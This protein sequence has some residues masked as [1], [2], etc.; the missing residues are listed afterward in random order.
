MK[1]LI[2]GQTSFVGQGVGNWFRKKAPVPQVDFLSVRDDLWRTRDFSGYDAVIFAAAL[3]HHPEVTDWELYHRIN[4]Q[5]PLDFAEHVKVQG[6]K[7]FVFF[8]TLSVYRA[9]RTLPEGT[10]IDENTPL[11]PLSLYGKSK[12]MAEHRLQ[13]LQTGDFHVSIVR[14]SYVYGRGCQGRHLDVKALLAR[15]LPLLPDAFGNVKMGMVHIDNLAQLCWLIVNS[16]CSGVY[17]AQDR[18]PMS[19]TDILRAL[20]PEKKSIRCGWLLRPFGR[21]SL[22]NRLFGGVAFSEELSQCPLGEYRVV[23]MADGIRRTM[24]ETR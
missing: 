7:Q 18:D 10:I 8:S 17:H 9:E 5:L 3:V 11:E 16:G 4:V 19:T 13:Q 1:I 23:S 2:V 22:L 24:E 15:K 12:L 6:V 14:S 21:M 20:A